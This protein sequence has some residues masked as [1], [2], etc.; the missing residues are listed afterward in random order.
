MLP[1]GPC[2]LLVGNCEPPPQTAK[3][4]SAACRSERGSTVVLVH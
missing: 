3:N 1:P 4:A 2:A